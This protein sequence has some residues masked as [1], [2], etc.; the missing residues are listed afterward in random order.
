MELV[1]GQKMSDWLARG[2]PPI[3]KTLELATEIAAG[4][5]RAHERQI[6]HRDLKP[7]N[8][9]VTDDGHAKII[10]FGIAKL[11]ESSATGYDETRARQDTASGVV[12]G[13]MTYMS[14]EQARGDKVDHRSDIFSFG[15][16]LHEMLSGK[17]P[18]QGKSGL[19]TASAI[20][21]VPAP[22]C[23]RSAP[24]SSPIWLP[25]SSASSTSAS[26]RIRRTATR[27]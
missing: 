19:E 16:V 3:A 7:A 11:L 20:L 4:L 17:P 26:K 12:L 10:D 22:G 14:P 25:I 15:I 18:F 13:T 21:H 6:V 9:M 23:R 8:V 27:A 24:T 5:S 1:R 2:R